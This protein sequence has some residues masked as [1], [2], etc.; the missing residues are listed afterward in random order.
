MISEAGEDSDA[1]LY[2]DTNFDL[3]FPDGIVTG[4][5]DDGYHLTFTSA[6]AVDVYLP[7]TGSAQDLVLTMSTED[8]DVDAEDP[9]CFNNALVS[10]LLT[11]KL[12]VGFDLFDPSFSASDVALEDLMPIQGALAGVQIGD[13]IDIADSVLGGCSSEYT[14]QQLRVALRK[15]NR[16]F[17]FGTIDEGFIGFVG[18]LTEVETELG[19]GATG[20]TTVTFTAVDDCGN[21]SSVTYSFT[22]EDNNPPVFDE[23]TVNIEMPCDQIDD[24]ILVTATDDCSDVTITY[25]DDNVSGGCA[26]IIIRDYTATDECGNEAYAEQIINLTDT[27]APTVVFEP[28]DVTIECDEDEPTDSPIFDDNCDDDLTILPA[29][30]ITQEDCGWIIH[31]SWTATDGCGNSTTVDRDITVLDTTPPTISGEDGEETVDCSDF[32][33]IPPSYAV[34]DNCDDDL[35]VEY[36]DEIVEGTCGGEWTQIS[37]ALQRMIVTI[38]PLEHTLFIM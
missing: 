13:I 18:C 4:C 25:E 23:Y 32:L 19:C 21:A 14:P 10:H 22:I 8:P 38:L 30:S 31:Q 34:A 9:T 27:T 24:A 37:T 20:S 15:F 29:S 2:M 36:T 33:I 16:N 1:S 12:N 3:V 6:D 28:A 26:G 7:C 35:T 11:A 17:R 5:V